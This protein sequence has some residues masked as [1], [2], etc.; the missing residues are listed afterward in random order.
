MVIY[1]GSKVRERRQQGKVAWIG[2]ISSWRV[3]SVFVFFWTCCRWSG[4]RGKS[5]KLVVLNCIGE[6]DSE[7]TSQGLSKV[8][9]YSEGV[10]ALTSDH[11]YLFISVHFKQYLNQL[12][13]WMLQLIWNPNCLETYWFIIFFA[14][15]PP[16][17]YFTWSFTDNGYPGD[18]PLLRS[19]QPSSRVSNQ[20]SPQFNWSSTPTGGDEE[21]QSGL[22]RDLRSSPLPMAL[23]R[24]VRYENLLLLGGVSFK[25]CSEIKNPSGYVSQHKNTQL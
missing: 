18:Q 17:L 11:I 10:S 19:R 6:M 9:D 13:M 25:K 15:F 16:I 24:A 23:K 3:G 21:G 1:K 4:Y 8:Y 2:S 12:N 5:L 7:P 14:F 20:T 22:P